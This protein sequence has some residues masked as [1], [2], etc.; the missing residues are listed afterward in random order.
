[1]LKAG[2]DDKQDLE[3]DTQKALTDLT[4]EGGLERAKIFDEE[5]DD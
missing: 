5:A 1:M 3:G 4:G 2:S